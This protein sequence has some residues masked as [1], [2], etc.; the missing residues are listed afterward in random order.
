MPAR[1]Y[2]RQ[3]KRLWR[4]ND[5]RWLRLRAQVL[6]EEPFCRHCLR[7]GVMPPRTSVICDHIDGKAAVLHDYRRE[8]LQGLCRECDG[9][10]SIM[11]DGGFGGSRVNSERRGCDENGVPLSA[12][13][14]WRKQ[15]P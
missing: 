1:R 14:H 9:V 7:D 12:A 5:K 4:T 13:H 11:Q 3:E 2:E 6:R 10:K 8:N 15:T